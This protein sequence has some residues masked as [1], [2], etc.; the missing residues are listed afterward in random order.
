MLQTWTQ[1]GITETHKTTNCISL[2]K[3]L[4]AHNIQVPEVSHCG[5]DYC[6]TGQPGGCGLNSRDLGGGSRRTLEKRNGNA[7]EKS[8]KDGHASINP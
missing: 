7:R 3:A 6:G 2:L 1:I 5:A 8:V 4:K